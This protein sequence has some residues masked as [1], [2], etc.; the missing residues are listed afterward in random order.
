M[1]PKYPGVLRRKAPEIEGA[2]S[3]GMLVR[4]GVAWAQGANATGNSLVR[5]LESVCEHEVSSGAIATGP[6]GQP[7]CNTKTPKL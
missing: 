2:G 4:V 1:T 3:G 7:A 5:P 6:I